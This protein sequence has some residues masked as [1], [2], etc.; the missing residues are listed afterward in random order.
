MTEDYVSF[1]FCYY[2]DCLIT[3]KLSFI[4]QS[5]QSSW[6]TFCESHSWKT[7]EVLQMEIQFQSHCCGDQQMNL[8]EI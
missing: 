2:L 4:S 7:M 8:E 5:D 6:K 1:L 3:L